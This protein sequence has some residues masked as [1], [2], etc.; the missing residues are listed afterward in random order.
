MRLEGRKEKGGAE[1]HKAHKALSH[2]EPRPKVGKVVRAQ[3]AVQGVNP[4]HQCKV[5]QKV[6]LLV[7]HTHPP[8][9]PTRSSVCV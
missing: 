4:P 6:A 8:T 2:F 5:R 1:V 3:S 7:A 9:C